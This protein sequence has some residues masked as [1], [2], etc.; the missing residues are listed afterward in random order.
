MEEITAE[1]IVNEYQS[2]DIEYQD[3][4]EEIEE[5]EEE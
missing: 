2:I 4:I 1:D 3:D 5:S